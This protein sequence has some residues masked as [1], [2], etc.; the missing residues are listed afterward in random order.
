MVFKS[1]LLI[2]I[3]Q[4]KTFKAILNANAIEV[5]INLLS[6]ESSQLQLNA[7]GCLC[8]MAEHSCK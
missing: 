3:H 7:A 6:S 4:A 2:F 8:I 5:I 1:I